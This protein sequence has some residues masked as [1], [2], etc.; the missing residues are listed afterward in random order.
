MFHFTLKNV[1]TCKV[2]KNDLYL[3]CIEKNIHLIKK[4]KRA[5]Q[6]SL[7]VT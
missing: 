1:H 3:K 2:L 7:F 5:I 6:L 4:K